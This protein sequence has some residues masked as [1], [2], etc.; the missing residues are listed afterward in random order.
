MTLKT[1]MM[2]AMAGAAMLTGASAAH[3]QEITVG[4]FLEWP[5]PFQ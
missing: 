1:K 2:S 4:Y 3:A 5:M